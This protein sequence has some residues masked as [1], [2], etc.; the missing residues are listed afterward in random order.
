M[1]HS[2]RPVPS[3]LSVDEE[4]P[5]R[6]RRG[7][8]LRASVL[9]I[10]SAT[11]LIGGALIRR[12]DSADLQDV[13]RELFPAPSASFMDRLDVSVFQRG[14]LHTHSARTDGDSPAQVVIDWYRTHGY[15]FLA[16][17]DH[18][19]Y[20]DGARP[21]EVQ[22][23]DFVVIPGE[24]ITMVAAMQPVHVNAIC[25]KERIG[26]GTF[27]TPG[28]AL[29][30][31]TAKI[32]AQD[33][34]AIVNHPNFHW[35]LDPEHIAEA[36]GAQLLEIWSGHPHVRS[37]GDEGHA[38]AEAKWDQVLSSGRSIAAVA[39]DDMHALTGLNKNVPQA[40]PGV[41]WVEVF[42]EETS[43][44]AICEALAAGKL[45]ASAGPRITH[46]GV[47]DDR[48]TLD[49]E[50]PELKVEFL[51]HGGQLL[52]SEQPEAVEDSGDDEARPVY[53]ASYRLNGTER[54][55]RARLTAPDGKRAWTQAY[56]VAR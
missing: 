1:S 22:D 50:T 53:R 11:L 26:G 13:A 40:P 18:N 33:G 51:D 7:R 3:T 43:Q 39:V 19:T 6:R 2:L 24:E 36:K 21:P 44:E 12:A 30:W 56:W 52:A 25:T 4:A 8:V 9:A 17:T 37:D 28:A 35:A 32:L 55:V 23:H 41:A 15:Q 48:F 16:L 47:G 45:Y 27:R 34:V 29:A 10:A 31:A 49:V 5:K 54:F 14:N 42:A 46:L 38:S 20:L